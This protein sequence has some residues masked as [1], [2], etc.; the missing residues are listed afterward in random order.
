[1]PVGAMLRATAAC[2]GPNSARF[3]DPAAARRSSFH[4]MPVDVLCD[5]DAGVPQNHFLIAVGM[6]EYPCDHFLGSL[7][8]AGQLS[9]GARP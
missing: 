8:S 5:R 9:G 4:Q 3:M 7:A 2:S 6:V 1:V